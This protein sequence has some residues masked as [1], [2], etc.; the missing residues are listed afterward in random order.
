M[1]GRSRSNAASRAA[2]L[3]ASAGQPGLFAPQRPAKPGEIGKPK[4][5]REFRKTLILGIERAE[6]HGG[7]AG[8][9]GAF[10]IER[11]I[12]DIPDIDAGKAGAFERELHGYWIGL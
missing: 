3:P 5:R 9:R 10:H 12:A 11:G 4:L 2:C 8:P 6:Q 7:T 1:R